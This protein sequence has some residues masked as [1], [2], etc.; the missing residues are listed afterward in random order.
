MLCIIVLHYYLV[1]LCNSFLSQKVKLRE[2]IFVKKNMSPYRKYN[3]E[4][5]YCD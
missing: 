1:Y 3:V 2:L 4:E 5:I